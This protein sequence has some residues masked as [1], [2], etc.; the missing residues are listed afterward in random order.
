MRAVRTARFGPDDGDVI[1]LERRSEGIVCECSRFYGGSVVRDHES[2]VGVDLDL[3]IPKKSPEDKSQSPVAMVSLKLAP[4]DALE[5]FA[6]NTHVVEVEPFS[7]RFLVAARSRR[8]YCR[9]TATL[10]RVYAT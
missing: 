7:S 2:V 3:Q 10:G 1:H 5:G 9:R 4:P 8:S 6:V